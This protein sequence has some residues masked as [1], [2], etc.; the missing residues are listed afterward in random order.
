MFEQLRIGIGKYIYL[1]GIGGPLTEAHMKQVLERLESWVWPTI[2][3]PEPTQG[4]GE[5]IYYWHEDD[6]HRAGYR[7]HLVMEW[8]EEV[9]P[10]ATV[11]Q[12]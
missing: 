3:I 11:Y 5:V 7:D 9:F 1:T 6:R 2:D 12:I 4:H 10:G 8:F